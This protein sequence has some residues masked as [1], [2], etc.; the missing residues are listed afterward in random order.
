[1]Y[2][3]KQPRAGWAGYD[4]GGF[5]FF[6]GLCLVINAVHAEGTFFHDL[7]SFVEFTRTIRTGPCAQV[8]ADALVVIH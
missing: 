1:M 7:I 2:V 5:P 4:A 3:T 6:N 8:A